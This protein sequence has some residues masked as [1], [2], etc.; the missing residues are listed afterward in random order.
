VSRQLPLRSIATS[1]LNRPCRSSQ[2][3]HSR[4]SVR[5]TWGIICSNGENRV[6]FRRTKMNPEQQNKML[7]AM[8]FSFLIFLF[9]LAFPGNAEDASLRLLPSGHPSLFQ[10]SQL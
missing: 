10:A 4:E 8:E 6:S 7:A 5:F 9:A 3:L 1:R 2:S